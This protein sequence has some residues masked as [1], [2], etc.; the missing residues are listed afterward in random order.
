[1]NLQDTYYILSIVFMSLSLLILIGIVVLVFYIKKKVT[2]IH[3]DIQSKLNDINDYGVKP[4]KKV[5]D[6]ASAFF[7]GASKRKKSKK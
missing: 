4:V 5:I 3:D 7:S 1:M 6:I 2:S